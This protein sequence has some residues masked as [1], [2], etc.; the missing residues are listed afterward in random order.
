M[1]D[2]Q[3]S[4]RGH[5]I[6]ISDHTLSINEEAIAVSEEEGRFFSERLPYNTYADLISLAHKVVD[7]S[8]E[9]DTQSK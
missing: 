9:F 2:H 5:E 3:E 8:A 4:Y 6:R 7:Q 1:A